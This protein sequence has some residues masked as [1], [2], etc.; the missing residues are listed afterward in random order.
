MKLPH[1]HI[2]PQRQRAYV[3]SHPLGLWVS[4]GIAI[5]GYINILQPHLTEESV[6]ALI[7]SPLVL[8]AFNAVWAMG[9]TLSFIGMARGRHHVE[10]AGM[11]LLASGLLSYFL[12]IVSVRA[13]SALAALFLPALAIGCALRAHHLTTHGYVLMDAPSNQ[14][15]GR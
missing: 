2:V 6:V 9:G 1:P 8:V 10:A 4:L 13:S 5:S 12:A 7:F 3:A 11:A 15:R 14:E